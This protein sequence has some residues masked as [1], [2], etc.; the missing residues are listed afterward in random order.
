MVFYIQKEW[1]FRLQRVF[2]FRVCLNIWF[3]FLLNCFQSKFNR[4]STIPWQCRPIYIN[5]LFSIST[6]QS[7]KRFGNWNSKITKISLLQV[8]GERGVKRKRI[9]YRKW[10]QLYCKCHKINKERENKDFKRISSRFEFQCHINQ[11][12]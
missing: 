4:M 9:M 11:F 10:N 7:R 8:I 12:A 2:H 1:I 6:D 3:F 5:W